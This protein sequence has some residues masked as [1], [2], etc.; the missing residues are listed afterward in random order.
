MSET[1]PAVAGLELEREYDERPN[2][3]R[4]RQSS[5]N[6][7]LRPKRRTRRSQTDN[8]MRGIVTGKADR[9]AI[10]ALLIILAVLFAFPLYSAIVKS[11]EVNG[12][13]NYIS[14]F[15]DPVGDV[16]IW[17]TYL[18]SLGVGAV[19]AAIVVTVSV[20]AGYAFSKLQFRGR[21]LSF[22]AVL[23]FLAVPGI[24]ILVPVYRITQ[25][26]G[27]FNTYLGVGLPEAA[28]TIPFGVLL[29]RNYGRNI[30]D[31]LIE[32]A[33][34][35]GAG[36]F[37]IFWNIFVPLSRP[38]IINLLV[39]CFIWSL[40]DFLWPSFLFTDPSLT[41]AA[42]AVSTFSSALGRGAGDLARFN[43]SLV[44]LAVPA[45]LFVVFG[46]RFIVNGLTT[47]STKD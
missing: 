26:L 38:A 46:L 17:Q 24:A 34:L 44:V 9:F 37:R 22:S 20:T 32:A 7:P 40:Q 4:P 21:E 29:M 31:S 28:I 43:A 25:E 2:D 42:Q 3:D 1:L 45:V 8:P 18:N 15:T 10:Y 14:L 47:G 5:D 19:H 6:G 16:P 35:D 11:L 33:N 39:L 12:I 13:Q 36:H 41:T 30:S 27:L 23:L